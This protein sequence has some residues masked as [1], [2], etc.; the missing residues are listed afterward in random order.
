MTSSSE[1]IHLSADHRWGPESLPSN[2]LNE[3]KNHEQ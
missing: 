1:W 2:T 3:A